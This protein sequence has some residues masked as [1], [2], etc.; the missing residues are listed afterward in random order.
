MKFH[1]NPVR[2]HL[3]LGNVMRWNVWTTF[4]KWHCAW[5][6]FKKPLIR[7]GFEKWELTIDWKNTVETVFRLNLTHFHVSELVA[8]FW[9]RNVLNII[10][11]IRIMGNA[12]KYLR[13]IFLWRENLPIQTKWIQ[14]LLTFV[15]ETCIF[16]FKIPTETFY[17]TQ[18]QFLRIFV[19]KTKCMST[20]I[21]FNSNNE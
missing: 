7:I 3:T 8:V 1:L 12:L 10:N 14:G 11:S 13:A 9:L 20:C 15:H 4:V 17:D 19:G 18:K 6:T 21:I 5:F 16:G 2:K